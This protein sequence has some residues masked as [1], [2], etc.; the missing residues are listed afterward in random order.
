MF[1]IVQSLAQAAVVLAP[2]LMMEAILL[3]TQEQEQNQ[4]VTNKSLPEQMLL[5]HTLEIVKLNNT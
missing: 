3:K 1:V 4:D 5:E 2:H